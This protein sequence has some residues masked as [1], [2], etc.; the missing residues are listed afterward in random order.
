M[1][2]VETGVSGLKHAATECSGESSDLS[3]GSVSP[4]WLM[5]EMVGLEV[6]T[7]VS[8]TQGLDL[9]AYSDSI[10]RC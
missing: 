1:K 6:G 7:R 9:P 8:D 3:K 10:G 2:Q 5:R 4:G